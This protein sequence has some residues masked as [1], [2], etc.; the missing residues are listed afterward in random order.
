[1]VLRR[2]FPK[3]PKLRRNSSEKITDE[4]E[5]IGVDLA[6]NADIFSKP[7]DQRKTYAAFGSSSAAPSA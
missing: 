1:M 3:K 6:I 5:N 7:A 2:N 4:H